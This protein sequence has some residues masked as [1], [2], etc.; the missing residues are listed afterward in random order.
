MYK[1]IFDLVMSFFSNEVNVLQA[2]NKYSNA[3]MDLIDDAGVYNELDD[4]ES[5]VHTWSL[6]GF[7]L[8]WL[9][10]NDLFDGIDPSHKDSV[11]ST[12]RS[13]LGGRE[14]LFEVVSLTDFTL[15]GAHMRKKARDFCFDYYNLLQY[16]GSS[17]SYL[18]DVLACVPPKIGSEPIGEYIRSLE[19][20]SDALIF[21]IPP[22]LES[23][24]NV[25]LILDKRFGEWI[26]T[27][28]G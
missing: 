27:Y 25:K 3:N 9:V 11:L 18:E 21:M 8:V 13:F 16:D 2:S 23:Y 19:I 6:I 20:P 24:L 5:G 1:Y 12:V 15:V 14:S 28:R 7:F 26:K 17:P 4:D 22:T 10:E